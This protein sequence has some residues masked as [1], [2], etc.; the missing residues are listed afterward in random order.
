LELLKT[1][2]F[3]FPIAPTNVESPS[4]DSRTIAIATATTATA[5]TAATTGAVSAAIAKCTIVDSTGVISHSILVP[6]RELYLNDMPPPQGEMNVSNIQPTK[7]SASSGNK[8]VVRQFQ[9][10][11]RDNEEK[12]S[13]NRKQQQPTG[14]LEEE[15]APVFFI[16]IYMYTH[17]YLLFLFSISP[18]FHQLTICVDV[19]CC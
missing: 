13:D 10:R 7:D 3:L 17:L 8:S 18:S 2:T 4:N 11:Q 19:W 1:N 9:E 12:I 6:A 15:F 5:A 16:G 14:R